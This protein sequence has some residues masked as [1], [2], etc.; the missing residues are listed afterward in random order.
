[1]RDAGVA[2]RVREIR[3]AN[4]GAMREE[5]LMRR[6]SRAETTFESVLAG[7]T[8]D[9][10]SGRWTRYVRI[11]NPAG[12][13]VRDD[14]GGRV[15]NPLDVSPPDDNR[16]WVDG[17]DEYGGLDPNPLPLALLL[18]QDENSGVRGGAGTAEPELVD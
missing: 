8:R 18:F 12:R 13:D 15:V 3:E 10:R 17:R 7:Y 4:R 11:T 9:L 2:G 5:A 14:R 16:G 6:M 1:M